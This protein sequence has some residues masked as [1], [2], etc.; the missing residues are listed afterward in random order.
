MHA[1]QSTAHT[2]M[3]LLFAGAGRYGRGYGTHGEFSREDAVEG[4]RWIR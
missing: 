4:Q 3:G 2:A 1:Q